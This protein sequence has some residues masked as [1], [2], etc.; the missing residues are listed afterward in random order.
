MSI[1]INKVLEII[2]KHK[3]LEKDL[4]ATNLDSKS[5]AKKSKEY[6]DLN[7]V[8]NF[9]KEYI[10]FEKNKNE[11]LKITS[12]INSEEELKEL[13]NTELSNLTDKHNNNEKKLKIFMLP[14]DEADAKNA[15]LEMHIS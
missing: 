9:A 14:K 7:E 3:D 5:Y 4:S 11:L 8:I 1:P 6:S 2:N 15:I 13:A 12:D 10:D